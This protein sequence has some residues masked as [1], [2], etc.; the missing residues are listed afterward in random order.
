MDWF[1][2]AAWAFAAFVAGWIF[3]VRASAKEVERMHHF[4]NELNAEVMHLRAAHE[5]LATQVELAEEQIA[6][7][8]DIVA[9]YEDTP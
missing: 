8:K 7:Q 3:G 6:R 1:V 4:A 9:L 5:N 2:I